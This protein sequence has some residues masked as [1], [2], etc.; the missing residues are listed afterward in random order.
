MGQL[1]KKPESTLSISENELVQA[2]TEKRF[3]D[4]SP[5]LI[6]KNALLIVTECANRIG[7]IE[8]SEG[9]IQIAVEDLKESFT[10]EYKQMTL[11]E[12]KIAVKTQSKLDKTFSISSRVIFDWINTWR[13]GKKLEL[14]KSIAIKSKREGKQ[15]PKE[16]TDQQKKESIVKA[17]A[18]FKEGVNC[19]SITYDHLKA[20][21]HRLPNDQREQIFNKAKE[22]LINETM[23][24]RNALNGV[25]IKTRL[26]E[27]KADTLTSIESP[28]VF[29]RVKRLAAHYIFNQ[30]LEMD[31]SIEDLIN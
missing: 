20:L 4:M 12:V 19:H 14:Q 22:E 8:I 23:E 27:I 28:A 1:I 21:G 5:E 9:I 10:K 25:Y 16:F 24:Q 18:R 2:L 11:S 6:A 3:V 31:M 17:F 7:Q 15:M 29:S 13:Q 30:C 26:K